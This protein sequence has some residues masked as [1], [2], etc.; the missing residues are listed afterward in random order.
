MKKGKMSRLRISKRGRQWLLG[1]LLILV[2]LLIWWLYVYGP[3][4][5]KHR[6]LARLLAQA[7]EKNQ[8]LKSRYE[9][10]LRH[11]GQDKD[12]DRRL[13]GLTAKIVDGNNIEEVNAKVQAGF[14]QFLEEHEISL[15]SYQNLPPLKWRHYQL[16]RLRFRLDTDM[17][18]LA[19]MLLYLE[20]LDKA[21]RL[22]TLNINHRRSKKAAIKVTVELATLFLNKEQLP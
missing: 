15:A 18:G 3:R 22:Q 13:A 17:E 4:G 1:S 10:L 8:L 14:Q 6:E 20:K 5:D 12:A 2:L 11:Q 9:R 19:D 7:T 21:V 16:G